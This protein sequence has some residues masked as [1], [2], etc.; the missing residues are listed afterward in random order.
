[1]I[2]LA[3]ASLDSIG[4]LDN[5]SLN[6]ETWVCEYSKSYQICI[7]DSGVMQRPGCIIIE[8]D[9]KQYFHLYLKEVEF[10]FNQRNEDIFRLLVKRMVRTVPTS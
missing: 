6:G 7:K 10:R 3:Y 1:M 8:E 4:T 2:I 9:P 5:C